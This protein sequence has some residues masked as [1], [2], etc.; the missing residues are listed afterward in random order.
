MEV[1]E[2]LK[3]NFA[4]TR[5]AKKQK[6]APVRIAGNFMVQTQKPAP[7]DAAASGLEPGGLACLI[8]APR[9]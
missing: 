2:K 4:V 1:M 9:R 6:S 7:P 3:A 8:P 5:R